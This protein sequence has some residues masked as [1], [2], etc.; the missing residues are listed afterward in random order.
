MK[1]IILVVSLIVVAIFQQSCVKDPLADIE[2]GKWNNE[3]SVLSIKFKNQVGTAE[4]RRIDDAK[5]G[6]Y[7]KLN[8]DAIP[9][10]SKVELEKILLSYRATCSI[11]PGSTL[12]FNN[13]ERKAT[14]TVTSQNG[15]TREYTIYATE[16]S[17]TL[18]GTWTIDDLVLYG[19]TGPEWWGGAVLS[20]LD[21]PWCWK[22]ENS[23]QA[24]CDNT[25]TFTMTEIS[26]EGNTSGICV[27]DPG[28]DGKYA[29][30]IFDG[31]QNPDNP[32]VDI[33]LNRFYRQI[34]KGESHWVRNYTAG[35]ITFT[36]KD[37]KT[38]IS[39]LE[40][41]GTYM[42][43]KDDIGNNIEHWITIPHN[44]FSF[45]LSGTDDWTHIYSDY[46]KFVKKPRKFF[47]MVTK[48]S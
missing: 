16:F 6:I 8:V 30:F 26:D 41:P 1:K 3:R 11:Q 27:N 33:D 14:I 12:D 10:L 36:D 47:V 4:I 22:G 21:K 9:D 2:E 20:L 45:Q 18:I 24:E 48:Q 29:D 42:L 43:F 40:N 13:A 46:D 37:G 5:G 38:T 44:A 39:V 23:P 25:L 15:K 28:P 31:S 34:P 7:I 35:T 32:G 17:E 19:G